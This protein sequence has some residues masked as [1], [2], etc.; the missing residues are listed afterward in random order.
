MKKMKVFLDANIVIA[1]GKPP[2][3]PELTRVADL[4][5]AERI[6]V[7]T[8]DL[9][10]AEIIR[11]H[12]QN[13]F[14]SIK[15]VCRPKFRKIV[16]EAIDVQIPVMDDRELKKKLYQKYRDPVMKMLKSIGVRLLKINEVKPND[17]FRDYIHGRGFFASDGGKKNQFPD[18]FVFGCLKQEASEDRKVIIVS[19]D[20]DFKHPTTAQ[21]NISLVS[22]LR[23]LFEELGL[24]METPDI[25]GFMQQQQ[26][27]IVKMVDESLLDWEFEGDVD[28]SEVIMINVNRTEVC[29]MIAFRSVEA[30]TPILIEAHLEVFAT[31]VYSLPDWGSANW[32]TEERPVDLDT[33][34]GTTKTEFEVEASLSIEVDEKGDPLQIKDLSI[35]NVFSGPI[36]LNPDV[37]Y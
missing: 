4:V 17:V 14:E 21:P 33:V 15:E 6:E 5:R 1:A 7:L 3:G 9:T 11:R 34:V 27:M 23:D 26:D 29:N 22:S 28:D 12:A 35:K 37:E 24:K 18:A 20:K 8:T 36:V 2:G 16:E 13:D 32:D 10:I 25:G 30:K 31:A 19:E